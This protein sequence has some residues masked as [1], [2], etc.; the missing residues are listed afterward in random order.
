MRKIELFLEYYSFFFVGVAGG[1]LCGWV[2]W[3]FT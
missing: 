2:L 1:L 3:G